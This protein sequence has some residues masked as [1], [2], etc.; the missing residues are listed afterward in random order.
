[1]NKKD[2]LLAERKLIDT[3]K[4]S[5]IYATREGCIKVWR[6]V[7]FEHLMTMAAVCWKLANQG[8]KIYT[9]VEFNGGGRADI[10]AINGDIGYIIEILHTESEAR[11]SSKNDV[12]PDDFYMIPVRTKDFDIDI[13]DL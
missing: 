4:K 3:I 6:G 11:F 13:F 1:M 9:E 5:S 10:V 12:Y 8:W 7:T 2:K